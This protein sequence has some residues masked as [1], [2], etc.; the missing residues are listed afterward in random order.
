MCIA[1]PMR[2]KKIDYPQ[3]VGEIDG[4]EREVNLQLMPEDVKEGDYV[5]VHVGFAISKVDE[6]Y[7]EDM[8]SFIEEVEEKDKDAA[9]HK[10]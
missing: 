9:Y 7:V 10:W 8:R 4:I 1:I 3:A 5:M 6:S 2:L